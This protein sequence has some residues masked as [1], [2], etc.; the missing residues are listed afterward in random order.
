MKIS[1]HFD[2]SEFACHC[3]CGFDTVDAETLQVL[4]ELRTHFNSPVQIDSGC[5]CKEYNTK[6]GGEEHSQHMVGRAA[7]VRV[8]GHT[9][10]QVQDYLLAKYQGKYGIGRYNTFTHIDTRT[11]GPSRWDLRT[12]L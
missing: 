6:I 5:R 11:N 3:G 4:E 8:E 10:N 12:S 9:P 1:E 2:R 7:D